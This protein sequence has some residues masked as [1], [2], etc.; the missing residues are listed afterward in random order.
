MK[1][2]KAVNPIEVMPS[3][4]L[5]WA[6][7][8][9]QRYARFTDCSRLRMLLYVPALARTLLFLQQRRLSSSVNLHPQLNL[10]LNQKN[11]LNRWTNNVS[12][13][14]MTLVNLLSLANFA[15]RADAGES[16]TP[17]AGPPSSLAEDVRRTRYV[18]DYD[19]HQRLALALAVNRTSSHLVTTLSQKFQ[20][21]RQAQVR[22]LATVLTQRVKRISEPAMMQTPMAL[23]SPAATR[24]AAAQSS[25]E[26]MRSRDPFERRNGLTS[27]P[28]S[29]APPALNVEHL[30]DEVMKQ[31]DRRVIARRER[32]G[33]I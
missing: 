15:A 14:Q 30:A 31:I 11:V 18:S 23:H 2:R 9:Q 25:V 21:Q 8:F 12:A 29:I 28:P 27:I 32:M 5:A 6:A 3:R 19:N 33:Q 22:E 7:R 24:T 20:V 4:S 17:F 26:V 1:R 13:P 16:R 10:S